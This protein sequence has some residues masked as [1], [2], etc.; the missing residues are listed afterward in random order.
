MRPIL[1]C[2]DLAAVIFVTAIAVAALTRVRPAEAAPGGAVPAAADAAAANAAFLP[3]PASAA[4]GEPVRLTLR[5]YTVHAMAPDP[6]ATV[7]LLGA[8]GR[9]LGPLLGPRQFCEL[10]DAGGGVIGTATFRLA[11]EGWTQRV[12]CAPWFPRLQR[13]I[14]VSVSRLG[15]SVFARID[16]PFG[17]GARDFRLVPGHTA[18]ATGFATGTVL[19]AD[20][21]RG[22]ILADGTRLDGWLVVGDLRSDL[23][24]G[25]LAL[26]AGRDDQVLFTTAPGE[27]RVEVRPVRDAAAAAAIAARYTL[28]LR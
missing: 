17:L 28:P 1:F 21:L 16:W 4:L 19:Y 7:P 15:R 20:S 12:S 13:R 10:A 18:A 9:P 26:F 2:R 27:Y 3:P 6:D 11:G 24:A 5:P 22:R 25:E 8:D 23:A 14:P